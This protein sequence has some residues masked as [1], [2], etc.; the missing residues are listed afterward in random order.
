MVGVDEIGV[1]LLLLLLLLVDFQ[2][3]SLLLFQFT[4]FYARELGLA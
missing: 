4:S 2:G 3:C 1:F